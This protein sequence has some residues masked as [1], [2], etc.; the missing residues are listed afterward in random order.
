MKRLESTESFGNME[1]FGEQ[2]LLFL[3]G[4]VWEQGK[5]IERGKV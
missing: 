4:L 2:L 5:V 3:L 1:K